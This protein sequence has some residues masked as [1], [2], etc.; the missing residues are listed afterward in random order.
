MYLYTVCVHICVNPFYALNLLDIADESLRG[1][2][3][4]VAFSIAVVF[5]L[6]V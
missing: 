2:A 1:A 4:R 3:G 5:C 6:A